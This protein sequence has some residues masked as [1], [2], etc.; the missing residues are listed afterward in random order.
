MKRKRKV[1]IKLTFDDVKVE[2]F[3]VEGQKT[4][5][6]G[7]GVRVTLLSNGLWAECV[8][9]QIY[10]HNRETAMVRLNLLANSKNSV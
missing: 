10:F 8:D 6:A 3:R 5:E 2:T 1:I 4:T 7:R 9:H